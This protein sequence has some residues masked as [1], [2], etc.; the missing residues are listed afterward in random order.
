MGDNSLSGI[1]I[2]IRSPQSN[3]NESNHNGGGTDLF[4]SGSKAL[5]VSP[6]T[7]CEEIIVLLLT[8]TVA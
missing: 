1:R 6:G 3:P 2:R 7:S 8:V 4:G 5:L